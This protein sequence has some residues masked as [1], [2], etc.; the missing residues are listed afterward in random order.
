[1]AGAAGALTTRTRR[2]PLRRSTGTSAGCP[3]AEAVEYPVEQ[4]AAKLGDRHRSSV[5]ELSIRNPA[6]SAH[7][8]AGRCGFNELADASHGRR[9]AATIPLAPR[10]APLCTPR[11][12]SAISASGAVVTLDI[13]ERAQSR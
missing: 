6:R 8:S 4:R 1:M 10:L 12:R 13:F 2:G 7:G 11:D 5:V 9:R 3:R